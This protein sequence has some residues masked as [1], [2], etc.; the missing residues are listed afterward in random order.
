VYSI[1][2]FPDYCCRPL[3]ANFSLHLYLHFVDSNQG[4]GVK[5][6]VD[7]FVRCRLALLVKAWVEGDGGDRVWL[8]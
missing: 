3:S 6:D 2:R 4:E 1:A 8:R 7:G 5:G